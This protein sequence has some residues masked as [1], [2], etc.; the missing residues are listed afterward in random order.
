VREEITPDQVHAV[1]VGQEFLVLLPD[2]PIVGSNS[3]TMALGVLP[4][5][6]LLASDQGRK[7]PAGQLGHLRRDSLLNSGGPDV[8]AGIRRRVRIT[9]SPV[10]LRRSIDLPNVRLE[11]ALPFQLCL[12]QCC[13]RC[14]QDRCGWRSSVEQ[15]EIWG[16]D[17]LSQI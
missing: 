5:A 4:E 10:E 17:E 14:G 9:Q 16:I 15:R 11:P 3:G 13:Q 8:V 7:R 12:V 6:E 1:R 2:E